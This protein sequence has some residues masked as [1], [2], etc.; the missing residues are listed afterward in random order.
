LLGR[1]Q[2]RLHHVV[3]NCFSI[4]TIEVQKKK[5]KEEEEEEEEE[6]KKSSTSR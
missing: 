5:K 1:R 3:F 6:R 2:E 4:E